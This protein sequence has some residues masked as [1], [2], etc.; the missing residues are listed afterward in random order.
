MDNE[1]R[2]YLNRT[3]EQLTDAEMAEGWHYCPEWDGMLIH[4]SS[5]EAKCCCHCQLKGS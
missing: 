4:P 3:G 1:R 5:E 2:K